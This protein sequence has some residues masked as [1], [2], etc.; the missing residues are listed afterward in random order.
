M[1]PYLLPYLYCNSFFSFSFYCM[2]PVSLS[3]FS[4]LRYSFLSSS[5]AYS[6]YSL[7]LSPPHHP[8]PHPSPLHLQELFIPPA[9]FCISILQSELISTTF[10]HPPFKFLAALHTPA[11]AYPFCLSSIYLSIYMYPSICLPYLS[12]YISILIYLPSPA[13]SPPSLNSTPHSPLLLPSPASI[14]TL[15]PSIRGF[16]RRPSRQSS[17]SN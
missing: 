8:S 9:S 2:S 1:L 11:P 17:C 7:N 13:F 5:P 3:C 10:N 16:R 14:R 15:R 12:I 4:S 6:F